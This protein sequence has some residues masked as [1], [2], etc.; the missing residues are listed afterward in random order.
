[1][2]NGDLIYMTI[3]RPN[4]SY[5]V[6]VVNPFMQTPQK[7]QCGCSEADIKVHKTY[8]AMWNFL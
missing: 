8:F 5:V 4:L 2:H 7:P 6:G 1:M 3:S